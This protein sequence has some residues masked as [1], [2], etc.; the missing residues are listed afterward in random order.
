[1]VIHWA[2]ITLVLGIV[3]GYFIRKNSPGLN[4]K[5]DAFLDKFHL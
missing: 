1:M 2:P 5:V 4:A 3:M